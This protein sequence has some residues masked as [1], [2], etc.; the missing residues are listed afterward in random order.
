MFSKFH[1]IAKLAKGEFEN[2]ENTSGMNPFTRTRV[3]I[4]N[5]EGQNELI[6]HKIIQTRETDNWVSLGCK[7]PVQCKAGK[8]SLLKRELQT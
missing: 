3:L 1:K 4:Y 6:L 7:E 8:T 2:F 5:K